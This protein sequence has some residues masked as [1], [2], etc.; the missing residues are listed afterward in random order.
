MIS[1][2]EFLTSDSVSALFDD[3]HRKAYENSQRGRAELEAEVPSDIVAEIYKIWGEVPTIVEPPLPEI[4]NPI[5]DSQRI[6]DL[7]SA[8]A[9]LA[10]GGGTT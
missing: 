1:Y 6:S 5:P 2:E 4:E 7:E 9:S 3:G 8:F 10:F